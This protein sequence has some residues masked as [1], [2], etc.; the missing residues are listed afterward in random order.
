MAS[1]TKVVG[2]IRFLVNA[3]GLQLQRARVLHEGLFV[4]VILYANGKERKGFSDGQPEIECRMRGLES[5]CE[6]TKELDERNG[7]G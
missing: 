2:A 4:P 1:E 5:L 6:V 7:E 3:R